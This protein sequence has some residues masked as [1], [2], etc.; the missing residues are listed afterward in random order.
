MT[1]FLYLFKLK[2]LADDVL[3]MAELQ[4][5]IFE[6]VETMWNRKN[7]WSGFHTD[8]FIFNI[9]GFVLSIAIFA[10]CDKK[11]IVSQ[12]FFHLA[13]VHGDNFLSSN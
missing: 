3:N 1:K 5:I 2:V 7:C 11:I 9:A 10:K 6:N 13:K 4:G 12:D 8:L